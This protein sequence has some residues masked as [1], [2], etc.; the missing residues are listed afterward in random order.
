MPAQ[1]MLT[2]TLA[3]ATA[4]AIPIAHNT[5]HDVQ[6]C[7]TFYGLAHYMPLS[8][9]CASCYRLFVPGLSDVAPA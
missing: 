4:D 6:H 2:T 3:S 5:S 7:V 1:L 9:S 8:C